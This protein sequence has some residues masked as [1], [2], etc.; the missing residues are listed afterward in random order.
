MSNPPF[1]TAFQSYALTGRGPLRYFL[2]ANFSG[3][4]LH[5]WRLAKGAAL[6]R[7]PTKET[8]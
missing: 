6:G 4:E 8:S 5:R 2:A 1:A 7:S 3:T